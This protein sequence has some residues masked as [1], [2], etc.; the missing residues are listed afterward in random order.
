MWLW[1]AMWLSRNGVSSRHADCHANCTLLRSVQALDMLNA[2]L[3]AKPISTWP[4]SARISPSTP[5][6]QAQQD[7]AQS[8]CTLGWAAVWLLLDELRGP[9]MS[10]FVVP[11]GAFC[12]LGLEVSWPTNIRWPIIVWQLAWQGLPLQLWQELL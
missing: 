12:G 8:Q 1:T 3:L 11:T 2:L 9:D 4:S 10:Q 5:Q 6:Q 7:T